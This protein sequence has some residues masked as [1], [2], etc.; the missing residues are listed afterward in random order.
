MSNKFEQGQSLVEVIV[1]LS[2]AIVVVVAFSNVTL[3]AIRDSQFAKNQN[4]A[5]RIAQKTLELVRAV[6]DQ[7]NDVDNSTPWN[8]LWG[9]SILAGGKCY[10]LNESTVTLSP[11]ASCA[12]TADVD[13]DGVFKR[14]IMLTSSGSCSGGVCPAISVYVKVTWTDGRGTHVAEAN[15]TLSNWQ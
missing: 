2:I 3:S 6:R 4:S 9:N 11:V 13:L 7:D 14:K 8:D 15:T 12:D 1:A 5:T 10:S